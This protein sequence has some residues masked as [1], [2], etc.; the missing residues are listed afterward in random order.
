[1]NSNTNRCDT[2][3]RHH[4]PGSSGTY[5]KDNRYFCSITCLYTYYEGEPAAEE[6]DEA[7]VWDR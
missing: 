5:Q 1:M 7:I 6:D 4:I 2:C 3:S